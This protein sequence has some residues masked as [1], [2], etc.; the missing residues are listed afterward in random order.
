MQSGNA[1][2]VCAPLGLGL[3]RPCAGA[4]QREHQ[5]A[6]VEGRSAGGRQGP[7]P[8]VERHD[9]RAGLSA[10]TSPENKIKTLS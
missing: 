8:A 10:F 7:A 9:L 1:A 4:R 6:A 2:R 3:R 5:D